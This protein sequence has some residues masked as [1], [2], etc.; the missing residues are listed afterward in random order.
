MILS[1][2]D[3]SISDIYS[4]M[5]AIQSMIVKTS[6]NEKT[7]NEMACYLYPCGFLS[8]TNIIIARI[9]VLFDSI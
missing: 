5:F 3:S 1:L 7:I 2:Y 6:P 4:F 8:G 9:L